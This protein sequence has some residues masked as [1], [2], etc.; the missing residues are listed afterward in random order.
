MYL[1]SLDNKGLDFRVKTRK[2]TQAKKLDFLKST[3]N[4]Q[5]R[6]ANKM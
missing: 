1:K 6:K 5:A 4:Q 2:I 3:R